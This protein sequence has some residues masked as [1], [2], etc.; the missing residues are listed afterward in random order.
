M[1]RPINGEQAPINIRFDTTN[2]QII[3][4]AM[5]AH[6]GVRRGLCRRFR[7]SV[8]F[9]DK[10]HTMLWGAIVAMDSEGLDYDPATIQT[11]TDIECAE[12][13]AELV[14]R[15]PEV[16]PNLEHHVHLLEWSIKRFNAVN[17]P[18][19]ELILGLRDPHCDR[20]TVIDAA[21]RIAITLDMGRS[22]SIFDTEA[23]ITEQSNDLVRRMQGRAIYPIG[24]EGLDRFEDDTPRII[25]G[26]APKQIT[27]VTGVSGSG[28]STITDR[29]ILEQIKRGRSVCIGAWEMSPG[30]TLEVLATMWIGLSR[31]DVTT[32]S[33]TQEEHQ[34]LIQTMRFLKP[35]LKFV[36]IP[37]FTPSPGRK[38]N[39]RNVDAMMDSAEESG[40]DVF[41]VDLLR[42]GFITHDPEEEEL[43]LNH[44]QERVEASNLHLLA[45]QQQ[46]MKDIE[47]R[48]DKRPTREGVKG[49]SAW[50]EVAD[51]LLGIH[52]DAQWKAIDDD[53]VEIDIL[54]QRYG[55][56]PLAVRF[57]WNPETASLSNGVS[58]P[59]DITLSDDGAHGV[60]QIFGKKKRRS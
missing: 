10:L 45:V 33:I 47:M 13:A 55:K 39:I 8:P 21:K 56:W 30:I 35:S 59:Y 42:K 12:Y 60:A 44:V 7:E 32:G 15:R 1:R 49:S 43:A 17:G 29:I 26:L 52:R 18:L 25:P 23:I 24:I 46:R 53:S 38:S 14:E 16:P 22:G 20:A 2:E 37:K 28:K 57:D 6:K 9:T 40:C 41:V 5:L 54:K 4:A 34:Q 36:K 58:I 50:V 31:T 51:T 11:Y 19:A 3:L 48:H 27:V